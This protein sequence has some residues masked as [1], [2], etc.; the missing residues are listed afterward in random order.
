M[1]TVA[2]RRQ[3][4]ATAL[5]QRDELAIASGRLGLVPTGQDQ[6]VDPLAGTGQRHRAQPQPA[7][8]ADRTSIGGDQGEPVP[9]R[10]PTGLGHAGGPGEDLERARRRRVTAA[11]D[12]RR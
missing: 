6:G 5:I 2:T 10:A 1:H 4:G 11:R 12:R 7:P 9:V 8:G 3:R